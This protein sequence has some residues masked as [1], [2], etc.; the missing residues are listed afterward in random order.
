MVA[1]LV[2][3]I[4]L[5]KVYIAYPDFRGRFPFPE[6]YPTPQ[7]ILARLASA[8]AGNMVSGATAKAASCCVARGGRFVAV[9]WI[10]LGEA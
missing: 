2:V 8:D 10:N 1:F 5:P 3:T 4:L 9:P 7:V 6:R